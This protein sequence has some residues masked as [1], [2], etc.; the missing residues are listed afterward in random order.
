MITRILFSLPL[1]LL[2]SINQ[3]FAQRQSEVNP[4]SETST[5]TQLNT[6]LIT[7]EI[8]NAG[9]L[10]SKDLKGISIKSCD[11]LEKMG[12]DIEWVESYVATDQV[13]CIYRSKNTELIEQHTKEAGFPIQSIVKVAN[14]IGPATAGKI[15]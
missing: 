15:P 5:S 2:T 6:Y 13:F 8:S 10:T 1:I 14:K 9:K 4:S 3:I 7:R 11:V 12:E